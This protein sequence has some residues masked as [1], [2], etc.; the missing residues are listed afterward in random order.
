MTVMAGDPPLEL[1]DTPII[2]DLHQRWDAGE[3]PVA[4]RRWE[5]IEACNVLGAHAEQR[6]YHDCVYRTH[7]GNPLYASEESLFG[8]IHPDDSLPR[9]L[10]VEAVM[11][12]AVYTKLTALYVPLGVG[13]HVDHQIVR[14]WGLAIHNR[15][16]AL[17]IRFY[18][19]YPYVRQ[20]QA[21]QTALTALPNREFTIETQMLTGDDIAAKIRAIA[22]H[23]S[24]INTFW[25]DRSAMEYDV[26]ETFSIGDGMY[27]ERY[28]SLKA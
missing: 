24:Q 7:N 1:P 5:D 20:R 14:D 22:C 21:V 9:N 13:H 19:E 25:E 16:P 27:A 26:R 6:E 3:K 4:A 17:A 11:F 12:H 28:W 2:R 10:E 23:Q 8:D 15:S 18:E